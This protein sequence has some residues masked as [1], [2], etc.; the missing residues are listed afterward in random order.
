MSNISYLLEKISKAEFNYVPFKHIEIKNFF[1]DDDFQNILKQSDIKFPSF[2]NDEQLV[3]HLQKSGYSAIPFPGCITNPKDYIKWHKNKSGTN[4]NVSSTEGF[5][6]TYRLKQTNSKIINNLIE[7]F[8]GETFKK[9]ISE[10]FSIDLNQVTFDQGIQKYLDGYEISPHPDI[11]LKAL[12]YMINI[13]P[14]LQSEKSIHHTHYLKFKDEYK[15]V[16]EYWKGNKDMD[17]CWV[18]WNWCETVKKQTDNNSV[19]IFAPDND[20]IHAVNTDYQHLDYQRTQIYGNFWWN[21]DLKKIKDIKSQ[22]KWE[23]YL[24]NSSKQKPNE[25]LTTKIK[26]FINKKF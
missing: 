5:G 14:S 15:Y 7:F 4:Y 22:P 13:N 23:N 24:I 16:Q 12:T 3:D 21:N 2:N 26:N 11:R 6:M 25:K 17:R 18:P 10:K 9:I 19:V 8:E 20:T 1:N